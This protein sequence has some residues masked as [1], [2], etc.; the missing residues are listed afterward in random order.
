MNVALEIFSKIDKK[1]NH[2]IPVYIAKM[3]NRCP[4]KDMID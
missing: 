3:S 4:Y 1:K 2:T